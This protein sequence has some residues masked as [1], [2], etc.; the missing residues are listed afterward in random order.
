MVAFVPTNLESEESWTAPGDLK[1]L[2]AEYAG[3]DDLVLRGRRPANKNRKTW[4]WSNCQK[5]CAE[6]HRVDLC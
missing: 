6:G 2:A 4:Y 5:G 3:W 1:A